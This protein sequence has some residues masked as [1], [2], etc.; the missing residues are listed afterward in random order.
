M[1]PGTEG[2]APSAQPAG[3]ANP[4]P[5]LPAR[6]SASPAPRTR[7]APAATGRR[8]ARARAAGCAARPARRCCRRPPCP[9]AQPAARHGRPDR[10]PPGRR[11]SA[12]RGHWAKRAARWD[13]MSTP[14]APVRWCS[15]RLPAVGDRGIGA[16]RAADARLRQ[17]PA[18]RAEPVGVGGCRLV[19]S[20]TPSASTTAP[21]ASP[22]SRPPATP[23]L[24]TP[25][26][27]GQ[28]PCSNA[29]CRARRGSRRA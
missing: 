20:C 1:R 2:R 8:S 14:S 17:G 7:R 23:K 16:G 13:S 21:G 11:R 4:A 19:P 15:A 12:G 27:R 10:S 5:T 9:P 26:Q 24:I 28:S 18:Q 6:T 25:A 29:A 3:R 22:G